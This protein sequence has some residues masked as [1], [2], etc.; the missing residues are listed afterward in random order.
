[1]AKEEQGDRKMG[2]FEFAG[3]D[4]AEIAGSANAEG[5]Y[6]LGLMYATGRNGFSDLVSAHK[7]FNIA[8]FRGHDEAKRRRAEVALEMSR[9]E[10]AAAQR[11][12][13]DWITSH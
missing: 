7:W 9:E 6:E 5:L 10:I 8:A 4:F 11:A 12:A 1:V 13:R 3:A 2:R